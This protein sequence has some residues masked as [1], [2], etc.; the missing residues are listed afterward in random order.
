MVMTSTL[1][2]K[3]KQNEMK[4]KKTHQAVKLTTSKQAGSIVRIIYGKQLSLN[5]MLLFDLI[6][7]GQA[8]A[9]PCSMR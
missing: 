3:A 4:R 7:L 1:K 2:I 9:L 5:L 8:Y 6:H